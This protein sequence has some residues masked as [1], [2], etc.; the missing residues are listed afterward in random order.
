MREDVEN[1]GKR[2]GYLRVSTPEQKLDRQLQ[3]LESLCDEL[4]VEQ[5]SAVTHYR[6]VFEGVLARL[7]SGDALVVWDLDRAFRSVIDAITVA[8]RLRA[9]GVEFQIIN[10][11]VDTSTATGMFVY[12]IMSAA[13]EYERRY[14][15]QRTKEGLAAARKRGS[16][17]G[18]PPKLSQEQ[19]AAA[20][21]R[22]TVPGQTKAAVASDYGIAPWTLTRALRR[23][24]SMNDVTDASQNLGAPDQ[25]R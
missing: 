23:E 16:R 10:L 6:P 15:V 13:A 5:V 11:Q 17:L 25:S 21:A 18:R 20:R 2:I 4:F 14:L 3:G 1:M 22:L 24:F 7:R 12:T 8:D 19:L 9:R